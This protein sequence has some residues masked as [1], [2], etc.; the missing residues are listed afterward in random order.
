MSPTGAIHTES[1]GRE[2]HT[3]AGYMDSADGD[4]T[5]SRSAP[6][7]RPSSCS[8]TASARVDTDVPVPFTANA[9]MAEHGPA[10]R[11]GN[12]SGCKPGSITIDTS[13]GAE[14]KLRVPGPTISSPSKLRKSRDD[15][16]PPL[17]G[18]G[19]TQPGL[20]KRFTSK[21]RSPTTQQDNPSLQKRNTAL[22]L[23]SLPKAPQPST[24]P[25]SFVSPAS[26]E[27]ALRARG[28]I[29]ADPLPL[30]EQERERDKR[31][32]VLL[33]EKVV[34]EQTGDG[35]ETEAKRIREAWLARNREESPSERGPPVPSKDPPLSPAGD[36]TERVARWL[37]SSSSSPSPVPTLTSGS[38]RPARPTHGRRTTGS[39]GDLS[40]LAKGP[41]PPSAFKPCKEKSVPIVVTI[42]SSPEPHETP[43]PA[44]TVSTRG[45]SSSES[46][47]QQL[48]PR[49]LPETSARG[50][51]AAVSN[52]QSLQSKAPVRH[53]ASGSTG[54][55][56]E[57][58]MR[59]L[60]ALSPTRTTS[61]SA[62]SLA[63]ATPT[64]GSHFSGSQSQSRTFL[65]PQRPKIKIPG[66]NAHTPLAVARNDK[67]DVAVFVESPAEEDGSYVKIESGLD[68]GDEKIPAARP[69]PRR[70]GQPANKERRTSFG[71]FIKKATPARG[72]NPPPKL[73]R[74]SSS[75]N[76]LRRSIAGTLSALRPK[77]ALVPSASTPD[78]TD[79]RH[80][81]ATSRFFD[82]S[83]LPPPPSLIHPPSTF[84]YTRRAGGQGSM[85]SVASDGRTMGVGLRSRQAV[86]PTIHNRGSILLETR[87][88]EDAESRRLSEMAFLDY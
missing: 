28:L 23:P 11:T 58:T 50:R 60:P 76:N 1:R 74:A 73:P 36:V 27:A 41:V 75:M 25:N 59:T 62:L 53:T 2:D 30:S 77:S 66:S 81:L 67:N 34:N 4:L 31:C 64:T 69:R 87:L 9:E 70:P 54:S 47:E 5:N 65:K 40:H 8:S 51:S 38:P 42:P 16:L 13:N 12:G 21:L 29:P 55:H 46:S 3:R 43:S 88:I 33:E 18:R 56:S 15:E 82:A 84:P 14:P 7:V 52:V 44:I 45:S 71:I 72:E 39:S 17:P 68:S 49:P 20:F 48:Q 6:T 35:E 24:L 79:S 37:Q 26:R 86:S 85:S 61:S 19:S 32:T 10:D 57:A 83:H 78:V 80:T 22:R 63:P